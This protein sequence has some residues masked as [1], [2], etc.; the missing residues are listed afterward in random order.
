MRKYICFIIIVLI[1][2]FCNKGLEPPRH[3]PTGFSGVIRYQGTWFNDVQ[4]NKLIA[5]KVYRTFRNI[6]EIL[7]L[8]LETDSIDVH[9]SLSL[10]DNLP[11]NVD[12]T[13]YT[14]QLP[15]GEYLYIAVVQAIG[16]PLNP[17]NWKVVGVYSDNPE[18]TPKRLLVADHVMQKN[19]DITVD[20]NN[21]PPQPFDT[22]LV[23]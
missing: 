2:Y 11:I 17:S 12:S 6:N 4:V 15:A 21:L 3:A 20:F 22:S 10:Q 18:W 13:L 19:I 23:R 9:P 1:G 7:F 16:D 5:S 14:F 8:V